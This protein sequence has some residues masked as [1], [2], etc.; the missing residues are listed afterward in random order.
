MIIIVK[1]E[2]SDLLSKFFKKYKHLLNELKLNY[3]D[4]FTAFAQGRK[5]KPVNKVFKF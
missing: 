4:V 3:N 5:P 2:I 1:A